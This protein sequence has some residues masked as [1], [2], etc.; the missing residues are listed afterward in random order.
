MSK[1][2][3]EKLSM[4]LLNYEWGVYDNNK[5]ELIKVQLKKA[6]IDKNTEVIIQ[7]FN[8]LKGLQSLRIS[9]GQNSENFVLILNAFNTLLENKGYSLNIDNSALVLKYIQGLMSE[10]ILWF[11]ISAAYHLRER[12][13]F[14][15][16]LEMVKKEKDNL[17][18]NS[19]YYWIM[20][21]Y[22]SWLEAVEGDSEKALAINL[23]VAKET[24]ALP[25]QTLYFKARTGI[26]YNKKLTPKQKAEDYLFYAENFFRLN[27]VYEVFRLIIEASKAY[28]DW[29]KQ[30]G[31]NNEGFKRLNQAKELALL[32]YK[33]AKDISYPN[34]EILSSEV[35]GFV[36]RERFTKKE[37]A[38]S[39]GKVFPNVDLKSKS[40]KDDKRRFASFYNKAKNLREKYAY[41]T[42][43]QN[44][45]KKT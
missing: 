40:I 10:S 45:Y 35:L 12:E 19:L 42:L 26:T 28:L 36:Y 39:E 1:K 27:Q 9:R 31:V 5:T 7:I 32:S 21:D 25:D 6:I 4:S 20:H 24:E 13:M 8:D 16:I 38:I 44:N 34:L 23:E 11:T 2:F 3:I 15:A 17:N 22:A 18:D 37:K 43:R 33:I 29:S 30:Q 41:Q 14:F